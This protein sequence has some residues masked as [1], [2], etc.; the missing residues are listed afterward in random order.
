[1]PIYFVSKELSGSELNYL[2]VEK[3]VYALFVTSRRLRSA[4]SSEGTG[5]GLILTGPHQEEHTYALR[6]NFKVTNNEAEYEAL[7]AGIR[8]A[9]ELG[10]KKLQACPIHSS[11]SESVKSL[12]VRTNRRTYLVSWQLSPSTILKTKIL[13]LQVFKKST[14]PEVTVAFVK[15]EEATWMT[16]IIEFLQTGSLP[17]N[18]KEAMKIRVK[19]S[20]YELR[21]EVLY[22]KSYL[23][24]SLRCVGPKEVAT[25]IDELHKGSYGLHSGSRIV[26]ERIKRLGYYWPKM[27][28]DTAKRIRVCQEC[29]LHAP[30]S[31]APQ[32]PMIPITSPWP[33]CKWAIDI[34]GPFPKGAGNAEYLV[35]A[36]DFFT[37]WVEAKPLR[38]ITSKWIRDFSGKSLDIVHAIKARL[39]MKCSGWVDELPKVLWVHRKTHKNSTGE[40]PFSLVYSSKAV[41]PAEITVPTERMLS[42]SEEGNDEKLRTNLDY[43]EERRE[44]AA[45]RKADNKQRIAKYYDKRVRAR[46]YKVGDLVWRDNQASKAQ[47]TRK[48]GP[49]WEGPYKV[50][51]IS[52]TETY[53]LA[54][55]K[56]NPI[57]QT[58]HAT[59]HKKCYM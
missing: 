17:E 31:R 57:K 23:G 35:V 12:G 47:N 11:T 30:V 42:Y 2:P 45:I 20:N 50:I 25:I 32:Q 19:A 48:L 58:R 3:L 22:R 34:V 27:Y 55:L 52:N 36:I 28:A 41:I 4:A 26:T 16:D 46:S 9:R 44:M 6:F 43:M 21:G 49:N 1:M 33:F 37:K 53:K 51:G 40:T 10:V 18:E 13:V 15:E 7:L 59:A 29:H 39:G 5:A 14:E 56:G 54:E 24:D 8:I 38:T